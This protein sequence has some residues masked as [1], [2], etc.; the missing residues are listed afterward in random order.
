MSTVD[1]V[2]G[3]DLLNDLFSIVEKHPV[4]P[5]QENKALARRVRA[6]DTEA[7]EKLILHNLRLVVSVVRPYLRTHIIRG[8]L[9]QDIIHEGII[10]MCQGVEKYDPDMGYKFSTYAVWWIRQSIHR[11][12]SQQTQ[13]SISQHAFDH[14]IKIRQYHAKGITDPVE[15]ALKAQLDLHHVEYALSYL[16]LSYRSLDVVFADEED[17]GLTFGDLLPDEVD[18]YEMLED[19]LAYQETVRSLIA[20]LPPSDQN[21]I[22]KLYGLDGEEKMSPSQLAKELGVSRQRVDQIYR[23]AKDHMRRVGVARGVM[24]S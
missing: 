24:A 11:W 12:Y 2:L 15:I 8:Q 5:E 10:G 20:V 16:Q 22:R 3:L 13:V 6:G 23:R 14:M 1:I 19:D 17:Q 18:E 9:A 7:R 4:L 21:V